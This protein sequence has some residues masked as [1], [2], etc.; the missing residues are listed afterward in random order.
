MKNAVIIVAYN[1][2]EQTRRLLESVGNAFFPTDESVDLI[3]SIDKGTKQDQ[4]ADTCKGF[5]WEYGE[6]K[7]IK[8]S[9]KM[10]LRPHILSC[11]EMSSEYDGIIL[12]ED[13]LIVSPNFY[14]YASSAMKYYN[15]D[16]RIAQISLYS[17]AVNE[18]ASRPFYAQ[19][20]EFD[21]YAM[22]VT[23]SWGQCWTRKMWEGFAKS[24]YYGL[25]TVQKRTDLPNNINNW[26]ENSWKKNFTNYI[27]DENKYVIYPY[28][29]FTSNYTVAGEHCKFDVPDYHVVL[30]GGTK[31]SY[32]FAPLDECITY[33]QFFER[34]GL[35]PN[36]YK[37]KRV[38]LDLYGLKTVFDG[39]DILFS[40]ARKPYLLLDSYKLE[41]KPHE[42][43][44]L[45][46]E[47]GTG[48]YVYDLSV[49]AGLPKV[50]N[51]YELI[52]YDAGCL[53][54]KR[55]FLH[56]IKGAVFAVRN[57]MKV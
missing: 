17:Y 21:V 57:R 26:K 24:P 8:R 44:L 9:E 25:S 54:W 14:F 20:N 36:K 40:T 51:N 32:A 31:R 39:Y 55:T 18:F 4:I 52:R 50:S 35:V 2:P 23:Q 10:G 53:R 48:I 6:Y 3:L 30:Q 33:D 29:S 43:N 15:N 16:D 28:C 45:H 38:C 1:R 42:M 27:I 22:K 37:D 47:K 56:S 19:H 41:L 49:A 13:D 34:E 7:I 46:P 12:L 5:T 11:G